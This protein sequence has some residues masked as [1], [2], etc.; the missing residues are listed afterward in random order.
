MIKKDDWIPSEGI[1]LEPA[2]ELAIKSEKNSVVLAG[3]GAG[4]TE[5]LAQKASY[6]LQTEICNPPQ[7]ILAI[8]F[9]VDA[10]ENLQKRVEVRC[11]KELSKRLE[12]K[13]F[14]SF[15]KLIVDR[16]RLSIAEE[17]RPQKDYNIILDSKEFKEIIIGFLTE[18]NPIR[19]DWIHEVHFDKLFKALASQTLPLSQIDSDSSNWILRNIWN[20]LIHGKNTL[21]SS[22]TFP[23][24]TRLAEFILRTNPFIK[25]A[26][27]S[28]Y[29]HIFLDEFQDTTYLQYELISTAF[30]S[31]INFMTAVGDNKQRIMGWAGAMSNSFENFSSDFEALTFEL[32]QNHRSAPKL[33][34]IQNTIASMMKENTV[35]V[36]SAKE[37][38]DSE[39]ICEVWSFTHYEVEAKHLSLDIE[40]KIKSGIITTPRD[41]CILTKQHEHIYAKAIM[42]ELNLKGIHS[43]LE[44]EYQDI[45]D[46]ECV[47][48]II[49][50][51]KLACFEKSPRSWNNTMDLLINLNGYDSE[52]NTSELINYEFSLQLFISS[53]K[54]DLEIVF[55]DEAALKVFVNDL[56]SRIVTFIGIEKLKAAY[57][58]YARGNLMSNI[59][60]KLS[61]KLVESNLKRTNWRDTIKEFL[62]EFSIPIMTIH[63]SKGLEYHTVYFIG[64]EDSAFWNF[65]SQQDADL[66]AFFVALSRAKQ[67]VYFTFSNIREVMYYKELKEVEQFTSNISTLY[68][69][70]SNSDVEILDFT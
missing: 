27:Q 49:D 31:P 50:V 9:K 39:G 44:K 46:D 58:K 34:E 19:P 15:A 36:K 38:G 41:I 29:S 65:K 16:F 22:I 59:L 23:M 43:R 54:E 25:K 11:G 20:L 2:A 70:L 32:T 17:Y 10:A 55:F 69:M 5:L 14:D 64:L 53:L 47:K 13:T 28:T 67:E 60:N 1:V 68:Q 7:K 35:R 12:S 63:K 26:L 24:I 40:K 48:L 18:R 30:N 8:S 51:L 6:F 62:G 21:N 3:P 42:K 56:I 4:K 33:V 66:C 61:E 52:E 37:K 45:I 57:P